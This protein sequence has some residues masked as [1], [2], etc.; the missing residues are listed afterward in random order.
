[1]I[2]GIRKRLGVVA[3]AGAALMTFTAASSAEAAPQTVTLAVGP[4]A[5]PGVPVSACVNSTCQTTPSLTSVTLNVSATAD[6]SAAP[7]L[8]AVS[9]PNG[10]TGAAV[11]LTTATSASATVSAQVS[12]TKTDGTPFQLSQGQTVNVSTPGVIISACTF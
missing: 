4:I 1:M 9:C 8:T 6:T 11:K 5:L 7:T 12:G 10:G 3:V 2:K